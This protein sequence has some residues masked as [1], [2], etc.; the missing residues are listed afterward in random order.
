MTGVDVSE[1]MINAALKANRGI[2]NLRF[3]PTDGMAFPMRDGSFDF[4]FSYEVFQRMPSHAVIAANLREINRG[5]R[6]GGYALIHVKTAYDNH[7]ILNKM[8][9][10]LPGWAIT[11]VRSMG[12]DAMTSDAAYRGAPPL[13]P[14]SFARL[15]QEV[16]L[17]VVEFRGDP[18]HAAGTHVFAL[19]QHR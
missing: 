14:S 4:V 16:D 19:L 15:C 6:R 10:A 2:D 18:T 13:P 17:A 8:L 1:G 7:P 12:R 5:L 11:Q 9:R 3:V